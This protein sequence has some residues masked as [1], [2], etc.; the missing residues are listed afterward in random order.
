MSLIIVGERSGIIRDA[1]ISQGVDAIS[2]DLYPSDKPGPH[3]LIDND[4][5]LKDVLYSGKFTGAIAHPP[6]TRLTNSVIWY[7]K[8]HNL[9]DEVEQAAAFFNMIWK[10]PIQ[11]ICMENPVQN[12][13]AK[14][15][16][17]RQTHTIQPWQFG[18]DASKRTCL[19]LKNLPHLQ[20]TKVIKKKR[21]ANQTPT[22]QNNLGPSD[23]R[24]YLRAKTYQGI[25]N[26][27]AAQWSKF[28]IKQ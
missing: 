28:F 20:P 27:M 10:S 15:H 24:A 1:F 6:C 26:A 22:G 18:E 14:K 23:A 17:E 3:M 5:H 19:W 12:S 8:K 13:E 16:I 4:M 7:I 11:H 21:Y 2:C 25:A 9:Y